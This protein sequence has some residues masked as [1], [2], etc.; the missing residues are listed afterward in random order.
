MYILNIQH[1]SQV[2]NVP[3]LSPSKIRPIK[4]HFGKQ[5]Y[6]SIQS[7]P[8]ILYQTFIITSISNHDFTVKKVKHLHT[9]K[10]TLP[11][12]PDSKLLHAL[13]QLVCKGLE[14]VECFWCLMQIV[15]FR[16]QIY[17]KATSLLYFFKVEWFCMAKYC[18]NVPMIAIS[19]RRSWWHVC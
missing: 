11:V 13:N 18:F 19:F 7:F 12:L 3:Y 8:L 9:N 14:H 2:T 10:Y 4:Q 6:T 5:F 15:D 1:D 16:E 17:I